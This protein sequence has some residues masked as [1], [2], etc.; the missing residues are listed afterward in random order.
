VKRTS[1]R[2]RL[3]PRALP[4][5]DY[6]G[7]NVILAV[8][9]ELFQAAVVAG[10]A[11]SRANNHRLSATATAVIL[12]VGPAFAVCVG[13][14]LAYFSGLSETLGGLVI[15]PE[16]DASRPREGD[17]LSARSLWGRALRTGLAAG[18]WGAGLGALLVAVLNK[19]QAGFVVLF[20]GVLAAFGLATVVAGLASRAEGVR[21]G[22]HRPAGATP[23]AARRRAWRDLALPF[24]LLI[25][26]INAGFSW[27]LFHNYIVGA[28]FGSHILTEQQVLSD[29]GLLVVLNAIGAAFVCGRAGRSEA[30][31]GL[32]TFEDA[33][34]QV[35][36]VKSAFGVQAVVYSIAT[37]ILLASLV[38]FLLPALPNL[39]EAIVARAFLAGSIAFLVGGFSY[40]RGAAN[41]TA[42][43]TA[44][45]PSA[46]QPAAEPLTGALTGASA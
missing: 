46:V 12:T 11:V 32:V 23:R 44:V 29:V 15:R 39:A 18:V 35:P 24:A 33:A 27:V 10:L 45:A 3:A 14:T 40:I 36:D 21:D 41:V 30:A 13:G 28:Q 34:T 43:A 25:A 31:M 1:L 6:F 37:V 22:F 2:Q 16:T 17:P 8:V 38:R 9:L 19:R 26:A 20:I 42:G 4:L 7:F 5:R